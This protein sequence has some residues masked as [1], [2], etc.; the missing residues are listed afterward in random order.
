M[1]GWRSFSLENLLRFPVLV[2]LLVR[3]CGFASGEMALVTG[4][5]SSSAASSRERRNCWL[6]MSDLFVD[7]ETHK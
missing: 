5:G 6:V 7:V 1:G 3:G 2:P 4:M